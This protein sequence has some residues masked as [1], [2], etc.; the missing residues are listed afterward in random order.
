MLGSLNLELGRARVALGQYEAAER[1]LLAADQFYS[2][3]GVA[4]QAG[5]A[6]TLR[7]LVDLYT[8]W[9]RPERA[10]EFRSRLDALER[11]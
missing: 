6:E 10:A 7:A 5:Y 8:A 2:T 1:S 11:R 4:H 9:E 3:G